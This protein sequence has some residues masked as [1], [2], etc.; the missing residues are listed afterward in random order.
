MTDTGGSWPIIGF[1]NATADDVYIYATGSNAPA[2]LTLENS[3]TLTVT[4]NTGSNVQVG[5]STSQTGFLLLDQGTLTTYTLN[6]EPNSYAQILSGSYATAYTGVGIYGSSSANSY[7]ELESVGPGPQ[8]DLA[9]GTMTLSATGTGQ[10]NFNWYEGSLSISTLILQSGG[11]FN[12]E[13]IGTTTSVS[14]AGT[15]KL[16]GGVFNIISGA[17]LT[18]T[19]SVQDYSGAGTLYKDGP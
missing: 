14:L 5:G 9:V 11:T 7:L 18:L 1:A 6:I 16:G 12:W 3:K 8:T 10:A 17:G 2:R 15:N 4:N 13:P 19:G